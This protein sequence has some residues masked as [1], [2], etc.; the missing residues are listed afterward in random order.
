MEISN[1]LKGTWRSLLR[2]PLFAVVAIS[3]IAVG[4][5]FNIAAFRIVDSAVHS[6]SAFA[7]ADQL[8]VIEDTRRP[9]QFLSYADVRE[10]STNARSFRDV[11]FYETGQY[12]QAALSLSING[13][14]YAGYGVS[15]NIL[16]MLGGQPEL[17]RSFSSTEDVGAGGPVVLISHDLWRHGLNSRPDVLGASLTIDGGV[18]TVVGVMSNRTAFPLVDASFWIPPIRR[19]ETVDSENSHRFSMIGRLNAGVSTQQARAEIAT[20]QGRLDQLHTIHGRHHQLWTESLH[21]IAIASDNTLL[22]LLEASVFGVLLVIALNVSGLLLARGY[23]RLPELAVRQALGAS[24]FRTVLPVLLEAFAIGFVG[25]A[26]GTILGVWCVQLLPRILPSVEIRQLIAGASDARLILWVAMSTVGVML[27]VSLVPIGLARSMRAAD[28]LT[29]GARGV[30]AGKY[31]VQRRR[32]LLALQLGLAITLLGATAGVVL[33]ARRLGD[34]RPGYDWSQ[35]AKL[36]L[37][38]HRS[39]GVITAG[40]SRIADLR[41]TLERTSGIESVTLVARERGSA[42]IMPE[43]RSLTGTLACSCLVVDDKYFST[44]GIPI[45][46]GR[47]F[48]R[49]DI[50][51]RLGVIVDEALAKKLWLDSA[52]G[53]KLSVALGGESR[54]YTVVGVARHVGRSPSADQSTDNAVPYVYVAGVASVEHARSWALYVRMHGHPDLAPLRAAVATFDGTQETESI[55]LVK[56][57]FDESLGPL[58]WYTALFG[59]LGVVGLG[60]AVLGLIGVVSFLVVERRREIAIYRALGAPQRSVIV[61]VLADTFRVSIAGSA[62]GITGANIALHAVSHAFLGVAESSWIMLLTVTSIVLAAGLIA[63]LIPIHSALSTDPALALR[64]L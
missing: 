13:S 25:C 52:V 61:R 19:V 39:D 34:W 31:M 21:D 49:A 58:R 24:P 64:E 57:S 36:D 47:S 46:A 11:G 33:S 60:V 8:L 6:G 12:G 37:R 48:G 23:R 20:L 28:V 35:V 15:G 10:L 30:S 53:R 40:A 32:L 14:V 38:L 22:L 4:T 50:D 16:Q 55:Q 41:A 51:E 26:L 56:D 45:I 59:L 2:S 29:S 5:A 1:E 7:N 27:L 63:T 44:M 9:A 42:Q 62:I 54:W 3:S 18:Y 43:R 17:G